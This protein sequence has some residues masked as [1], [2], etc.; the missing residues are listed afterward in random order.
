MPLAPAPLHRAKIRSVPEAFTRAQAL[1]AVGLTDKQAKL[2]ERT[3]LVQPLDDYAFSD[4]AALRTLARL[5][6]RKLPAKRIGE[7]LDAL[8]QRL[9]D[10]QNPLSELK[11]TGDG[12]RIHVQ[13]G[14]IIMDAVSGQMLLDFADAQASQV[15]ELPRERGGPKEAE[16]KRRE[17]EHWFQK[18]VDLEQTET[19]LEK[20]LDA[21]RIALALDPSLTAAMV[22]MGTIYFSGRLLDKAEK[23]Y[24]M[25]VEANPLYALAQ[26]NL[27]NLHDERGRADEAMQ[28]YMAAL[29]LDPQYADAH[30]N[31]ALLNQANGDTL[32]AMHHWRTYLRLDP[33][34]HWSDLAKRE[35]QKLYQS[36]V[37]PGSRGKADR[38][39][40]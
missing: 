25:A 28:H 15:V 2:L 8:K 9:T 14:T 34:S 23:Y 20:A 39:V 12:R 32:K 35:L 38:A 27:G 36:T 6:T 10:S 18:G 4:L 21:Y 33:T 5:R 7:I 29:K 13:L 19:E 24:T 1:R 11:L 26:F 31:V 16:R 3:G 22:N 40:Y 17:A 30:Y 37:L